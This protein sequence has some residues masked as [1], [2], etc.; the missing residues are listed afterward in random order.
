MLSD[1]PFE[2]PP[3]LLE[4][5]RQLAPVRTA[6][7]GAGTALALES[8]RAAAE[9]D[10][11]TP[12]LIGNVAAIRAAATE[13]AWDITDIEIRAADDDAAD[14]GVALARDGDVV[15]LMKG[16]VRSDDLM[17]AAVHRTRGIRGKKRP[18]HIFHMTTPGSEKA[19]CITDAV[20]NVLPK[21]KQK[22]SIAE[23]AADLLHALGNSNPN[24]AML[25]ATEVPTDQMPSSV[26][27]AEVVRKARAGAITG[28]TVDGPMALDIAV[29]R[30][31]AKVKGITSPVAG[32]ADVLLVPNIEAG[33][34]LFKQMV[35]F[36]SATAAGL[37]VGTTAPIALT[38]RADPPEARLASVALAAI[39]ANHLGGN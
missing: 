24:I 6:I 11:I 33:N 5:A 3:W 10:L 25:S 17:R 22:I 16:S 38:S 20:I 26:E 35:Y 39:Y 19:L 8:T 9:A 13:I 28:A 34:I 29:S 21:V 27:A 14:V 2:C 7:I 30:K 31:A 32:N 15:A 18:S 36:M 37:V 12:V 4:R 23:N 1:Q